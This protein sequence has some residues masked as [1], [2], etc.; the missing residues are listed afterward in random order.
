MTSLKEFLG[1]M[2]KV[3]W[4]SI[5]DFSDGKESV[6][7]ITKRFKGYMDL[8]LKNGLSFDGHALVLDLCSGPVGFGCVCPNTIA[9]DVEWPTVKEV[10][11]NGFKGVQGDICNLEFDEETFDIV[12]SFFPPVDTILQ[13]MQGLH[14]PKSPETD[15]LRMAGHPVAKTWQQR[16]VQY[17]APLVKPK[18]CLIL[19]DNGALPDHK[20]DGIF[21]TFYGLSVAK[22]IQMGKKGCLYVF[23]KM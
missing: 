9:L 8:L 14:H 7:E 17:A 5:P 3:D 18:G 23:D 13:S 10:R 12:L 16:Y 6:E 20:L 4:S 21:L 22:E 19:H 15:R 11:K 1:K 2:E